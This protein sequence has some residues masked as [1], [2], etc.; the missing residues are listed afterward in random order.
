M[1]CF[2]SI[3][4]EGG[5]LKQGWDYPLNLTKKKIAFF[6][7]LNLRYPIFLLFSYNFF[8]G[9]KNYIKLNVYLYR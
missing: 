6:N 4:V 8:C 5:C 1:Q 2:I 7:Q 9:L 3:W